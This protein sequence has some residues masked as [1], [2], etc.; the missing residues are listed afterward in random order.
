MSWGANRNERTPNNKITDIENTA[1]GLNDKNG[2]SN[3]VLN[4]L[5]GI[6]S[7]ITQPLEGVVGAVCGCFR[8][9]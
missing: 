5:A 7:I 9:L 4:L 3:E 1:L 2:T 8:E 6:R